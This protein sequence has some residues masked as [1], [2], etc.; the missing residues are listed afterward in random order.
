MARVPAGNGFY[1]EAAV[2]EA[3]DGGD[4]PGVCAATGRHRHGRSVAEPGKHDDPPAPP[5]GAAPAEV[6]GQRAGTREGR[7]LHALRKQTVGPAFGIIKQAMG[8]RRFLLRGLEKAGLERALVT[9]ACN[10]KRPSVLGVRLQKAWAGFLPARE[11]LQEPPQAAGPPDGREN[12]FLPRPL[13]ARIAPPGPQ[14]GTRRLLR[15]FPSSCPK[16]D[17][18]PGKKRKKRKC[19]RGGS[20]GWGEGL[21]ELACVGGGGA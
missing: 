18:L 2:S 19:L 10:L 13:P 5:P 7:E 14:Q 11:T 16:S 9:A 20:W 17:R 4:G 12:R 3:E 8:F 1:G 15:R 21:G 6:M